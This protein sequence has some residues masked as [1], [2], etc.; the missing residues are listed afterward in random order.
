MREMIGACIYNALKF[1]FV[2]IGSWF[3]SQENFEYI[4]DWGKHFIA[5][6]KSSSPLST[7]TLVFNIYRRIH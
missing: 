3:V 2:L 4:T 5:A 6:F 7:H 1:R